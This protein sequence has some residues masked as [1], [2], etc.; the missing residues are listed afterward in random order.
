MTTI[1]EL[2]E[3]GEINEFVRKYWKEYK[4]NVPLCCFESKLRESERYITCTWLKEWYTFKEF[5]Q[6]CRECQVKIQEYLEKNAYRA[7]S[8]EISGKEMTIGQSSSSKGGL[9]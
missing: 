6:K 8:S 9:K 4:G 7:I 3:G 5:E 2:C 1:R